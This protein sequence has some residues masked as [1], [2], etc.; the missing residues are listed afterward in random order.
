MNIYFVHA[1]TEIALYLFYSFFS[2]H[3]HG[4]VPT[5]NE[6]KASEVRD[7]QKCKMECA[8][9]YIGQRDS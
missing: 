8:Q 6:F 3:L 5:P 1:A 2:L 7:K 9:V 4:F